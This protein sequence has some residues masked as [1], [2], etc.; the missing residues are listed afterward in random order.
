[1]STLFD[2]VAW[3]A[4]GLVAAIAQDVATGDILMMAWMNRESLTRTIETGDAVYWSR[5]RQKLWHKGEES[6]HFQRVKEIRLDCDGDAILLKVDQVGGVACH[7]LRRSCFFRKLESDRWVITDVPLK[8][9][10]E[11]GAYRKDEV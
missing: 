7:T 3:N 8:P 9:L 2:A 10:S 5:S 11:A 4:D 6:G 1:M